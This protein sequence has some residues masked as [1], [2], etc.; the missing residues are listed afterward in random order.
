MS[1]F[2][3]KIIKLGACAFKKSEKPILGLLCWSLILLMPLWIY[4]LFLA[5]GKMS[6]QS[7]IAMSIFTVA[8]GYSVWLKIV[9]PIKNKL[10]V[11]VPEIGKN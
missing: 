1:N 11:T 5:L 3:T 2:P 8:G 9:K 6:F 7:V 10:K 4:G